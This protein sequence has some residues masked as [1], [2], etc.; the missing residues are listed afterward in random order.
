[1]MLGSL[2]TY[3][4]NHPE[5]VDEWAAAIHDYGTEA[6]GWAFACHDL[7]T[8]T[9]ERPL[10]PYLMASTP[11]GLLFLEPA[12]GRLVRGLKWPYFCSFD[13]N[14]FTD[15]MHIRFFWYAGGAM[16]IEDRLKDPHPIRRDECEGWDLMSDAAEPLIGVIAEHIRI[17]GVPAD[18][19]E[20]SRPS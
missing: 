19:F 6:D 10:R 2:E 20:G 4:E 18:R 8:A 13:A 15:V 9:Q 12:A 16:K 5:V 17:A 3:A 7:S 1:M 14:K 11:I